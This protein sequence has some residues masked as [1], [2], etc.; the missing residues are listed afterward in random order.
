MDFPYHCA[1][2]NNHKCLSCTF[3]NVAQCKQF[4]LTMQFSPVTMG[5]LVDLAAKAKHQAP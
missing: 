5:T 4:E 3:S 2:K 1:N